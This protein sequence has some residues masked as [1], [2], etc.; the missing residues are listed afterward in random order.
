[1]PEISDFRSIIGL[2]PSPDAMAAEIGAGAAAVRKWAQR[3]R[4]PSEWWAAV[5]SS[6]R[7]KAAN[8]TSDLLIVLAAREV[9]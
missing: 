9:A 3:D 1:M 6:P 4:I 7:A 8:V 2:W 5:V